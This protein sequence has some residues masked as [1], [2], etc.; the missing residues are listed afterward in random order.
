[1]TDRENK[2]G[3]PLP[4]LILA[5]AIALAG[6]TVAQDAEAIL[7]QR[8]DLMKGQ[9]AATKK[10][11][12]MLKGEIP[13]D[14]A[15]ALESAQSLEASAPKIPELFPESTAGMSEWALPVIW[16][17][18]DEFVQKAEALPPATVEL[19]A[20]VQDASAP[21]DYAPAM[22]A[23]GNACSGCHETFRKPDN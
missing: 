21:A 6:P 13:F 18:H 2:K 12:Q 19:V 8:E 16:E 15:S 7:K 11:V 10:L 1:M 9:G 14:Q 17:R 20:A 22:Q 5:G 3:W 4:V 23:V